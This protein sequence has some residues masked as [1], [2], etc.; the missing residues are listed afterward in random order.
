MVSIPEGIK[1]NAAER[2]VGICYHLAGVFVAVAVFINHR[3]P[4]PLHI[5]LDEHE[6]VCSANFK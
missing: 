2:E 1:L 6:P 5:R 3:R 4:A